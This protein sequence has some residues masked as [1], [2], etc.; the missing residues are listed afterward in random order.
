M[1]VHAH[2]STTK[3]VVLNGTYT[4]WAK[5]LLQGPPRYLAAPSD[6]PV[7]VLLTVSFHEVFNRPC[8]NLLMAL[9]GV[10]LVYP[11][12]SWVRTFQGG[13]ASSA[14]PTC[15]FTEASCVLYFQCPGLVS[16]SH[17]GCALLHFTKR[18]RHDNFEP[19][20]PELQPFAKAE[21][22]IMLHRP[23]VIV[24]FRE[25]SIVRPLTKTQTQDE[26]LW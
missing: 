26:E 21:T 6:R 14:P 25:R 18:L 22:K 24:L 19:P 12:G 23:R 10:L 11:L 15:M 7:T 16:R 2:I 8:Q 4:Q 17:N 13:S 1:V 3:L 5:L 9:Q 20:S